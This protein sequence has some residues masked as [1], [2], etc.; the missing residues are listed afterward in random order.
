MASGETHPVPPVGKT[1][2][3][4]RKFYDQVIKITGLMGQKVSVDITEFPKSGNSEIHKFRFAEDV[5]SNFL[6]ETT[7]RQNLLLDYVG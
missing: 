5:C 6:R 4:L 1:L 2:G 7:L 3:L